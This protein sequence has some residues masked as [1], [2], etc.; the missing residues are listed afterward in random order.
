[1]FQIQ[2]QNQLIFESSLKSDASNGKNIF[3]SSKGSGDIHPKRS[4]NKKLDSCSCES[5]YETFVEFEKKA[6]FHAKKFE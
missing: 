1:M 2:L 4:L 6:V 5:L 3:C